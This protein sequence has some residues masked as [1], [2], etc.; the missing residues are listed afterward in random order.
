M[1]EM[2]IRKE[3]IG[4]NEP[5]YITKR[6]PKSNIITIPALYKVSPLQAYIVT[7]VCVLPT[8]VSVQS[9]T[10]VFYG[11]LVSMLCVHTGFFRRVTRGVNSQPKIKSQYSH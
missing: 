7:N 1:Q 6:Q 3:K 8:N 4:M 11:V 2:F 9:P 10:M 5:A